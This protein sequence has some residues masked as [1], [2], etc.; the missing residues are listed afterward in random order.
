MSSHHIVKEDQEPALLIADATAVP[1]EIIQQLLE[2]S[3]TVLVLE[4]AVEEV[5]TW[6]IKIDLVVGKDT[7]VKHLRE[8]LAD[9]LP[10]K[11]LSFLPGEEPYR[12]AFYFLL[13]GKYHSVNVVGVDPDLLAEFTTQMDIVSFYNHQRWSYTR[14]GKF[15][16]WL[17]KGTRI[18]ATGDLKKAGLDKQGVVEE[19]G[20]VTVQSNKP[21][22]IGETY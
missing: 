19:D 8:L 16:K 13:A 6:G 12:T 3:P 18:T 7:S 21:F 20:L 11:I 2:W 5:L 9:Q 14:H 17:T 15:E 1:F 22:W 4:E 10:V